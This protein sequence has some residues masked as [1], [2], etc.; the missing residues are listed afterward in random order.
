MFSL[1]D[2]VF[3]FV[4]VFMV[5][6]SSVVFIHLAFYTF[7]GIFGLVKPKRT[8]TLK[9][10]E[11]KFLFIIPAHNEEAVIGNCL[12]SLL[13]MDY[14]KELYDAVVLA[15]HC[16]DNTAKIAK[17]YPTIKVF[18]NFYKEGESRGKPHVIAKYIEQFKEEWLTYDYLVL[19]DA[20]NVVLENFLTEMNSQF[21]EQEGYTVIQGYLDSKNVS[22]SMMSRGYAAAYFITNRAIQYSKHRLGWNTAIGGTGFAISTDYIEKEGWNPRSYTEDFEIQVELS[23][24]GLKSTWNHFA[25]VYDEKP[26][27]LSVSHTQRTRWAQGHW[28]VGITKTPEQIKSLFKKQTLVERLSRIETL[29]YSYSMLRS[30]W[31]FILALLVVVDI[32]FAE[33]FPSFFSLFWFWVI[34]EVLNY[35]VLPNVYIYQEGKDY[36]KGFSSVKKVKEFILLWIGY[37]YSTAM[38]YFAQVKG[39]FTWFYP[40]NHWK[41]TTHSSAVTIEDVNHKKDS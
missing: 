36:F 20:D 38:Y 25:K 22:E 21:L 27:R 3:N 24:K 29:V 31:L 23:I 16:S 37:F 35:L 5:I 13:A 2:K 30:V 19:L 15:D 17:E 26:N 10:D 8:Y 7:L 41:K 28:F 14:K 32:R 4:Y 6:M 40:Q 12:D 34:F 33:I 11:K 9:N 18:E 39:F 1:P